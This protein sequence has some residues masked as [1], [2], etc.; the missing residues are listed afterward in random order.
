[1]KHI[2]LLDQGTI[3][4]FHAFNENFSATIPLGHILDSDLFTIVSLIFSLLAIA[5]SYMAVGT[6]MLNFMKDLTRPG[7]VLTSPC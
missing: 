2:G 1:M 5:T 6:G 3:S 7:L 4:F